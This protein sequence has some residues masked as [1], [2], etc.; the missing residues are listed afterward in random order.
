[1]LEF[2]VLKKFLKNPIHPLLGCFSHLSIAFI[3]SIGIRVEVTSLNP[4]GVAGEEIVGRS[5]GWIRPSTPLVFVV[6]AW[7][8][9]L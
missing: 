4:K 9:A 2:V 3:F 8:N 6:G 7:V 5:E 1:M